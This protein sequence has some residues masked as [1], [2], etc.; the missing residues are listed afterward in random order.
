MAG[1][2]FQGVPRFRFIEPCQ[3]LLRD[4]PPTGAEWS[5]EVKFDGSRVQLQ[6]RGG[7]AVIF[8]RNGFDFTNRFPTIARAIAELPAK[9]VVIDGDLVASNANGMSEFRTLHGRRAA[10]SSLCVWAFDILELNEIDLRHLPLAKRRIR[11]GRLLKRSVGPIRR[12]ETFEDAERLLIACD[13]HG[14]E[15]I[16]SKRADAPYVSGKTQTWI[17]VNCQTWR[18]AGRERHNVFERQ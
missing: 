10:T 12:S 9:S 4:Y 7:I 18:E 13:E 2:I 11:L 16:V 14:L 6:K 15:G 8:S 1:P 17:K 5:H 3:P